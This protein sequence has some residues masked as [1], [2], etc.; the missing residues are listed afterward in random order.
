M[1]Q[2]LQP[3]QLVTLQL[4]QV[5]QLLESAQ[6]DSTLVV[7]HQLL[8]MSHQVQLLALVQQLQQQLQ[9]EDLVSQFLFLGTAQQVAYSTAT[10]EL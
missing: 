4:S 2:I 9:S 10:M 3:L 6:Q 7:V 1:L 5:L 8:L